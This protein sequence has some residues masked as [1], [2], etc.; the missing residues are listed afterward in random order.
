VR[1]RESDAEELVVLRD[2]SQILVRQLHRGDAHLLEEGFSRL[3]AESRRLRFL[4]D[5]TKLSAAELRY[6]TQ[7]DHHDHEAIGARD[8]ADGRGV[9]VARFIRDREQPD[10]AEIAVAV[11][12]DWQHRGVASELLRRLFLRAREEG[13]RRFTALVA[14]DN[15]AVATLLRDLGGVMRYLG[16]EAG[17]VSYEITPAPEGRGAELQRLLRAFGRGELRAPRP[18]HEAPDDIVPPRLPT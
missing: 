15:E 8:A 5:K 4:S 6:F 1:R 10:V 2:G 7:V 17:A 3:S 13:I 16:H 14:D 9:G 11:I 12:D 18:I